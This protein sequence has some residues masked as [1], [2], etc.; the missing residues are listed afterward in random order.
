MTDVHKHKYVTGLVDAAIRS[1]CENLKRSD[2]PIHL[3]PCAS[4]GIVFSYSRLCRLTGPGGSPMPLFSP[5]LCGR[6]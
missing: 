4:T 3:P 2:S 6:R 5:L 1:L